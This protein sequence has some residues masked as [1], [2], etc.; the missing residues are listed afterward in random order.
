MS[1]DE[2]FEAARTGNLESLRQLVAADPALICGAA[3]H[4]R[5][6]ADD[7]A[8][9]QA[10]GSGGLARR[11]GRPARHLCG[12]RGGRDGDARAPAPRVDGRTSTRIR[13]T[14]GRLSTL[15]RFSVSVPRSSGCWL[16]VPT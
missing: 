2:F 4:G 3:G 13:T 6:A 12:C 5:N 11:R 14:A 8:V 9:Q 10:A 15:R 1:T 7:G 16:P